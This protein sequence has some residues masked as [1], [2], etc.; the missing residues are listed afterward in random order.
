MSSRKRNDL[1]I[2]LALAITAAVLCSTSLLAQDGASLYKGKCAMCHGPDGKGDSPMGKKL[3]VRDL[4]APDVQKQT[5]A[6]LATIIEK[7]KNKMPAF[8]GKLTSEQITQLVAHIRELGK[9]KK[10]K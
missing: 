2:L 10:E 7:G 8:S 4:G 1:S 9:Q 5:G 6:E 3:N